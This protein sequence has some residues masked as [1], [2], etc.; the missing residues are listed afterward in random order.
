MLVSLVLEPHGQGDVIWLLFGVW[1][2]IPGQAEVGV[3]PVCP[4]MPRVW[5]QPPCS[6]P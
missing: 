2:L 1:G 6:C 4:G 3:S 5:A